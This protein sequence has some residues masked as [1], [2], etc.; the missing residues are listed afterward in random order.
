MQPIN[1]RAIH[2]DPDDKGIEMDSLVNPGSYIYEVLVLINLPL[3]A[4]KVDLKRSQ[5]EDR[6]AILDH[7]Y[8]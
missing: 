5:W 1:H 6:Q 8:V 3:Y 7:V 4:V 2:V